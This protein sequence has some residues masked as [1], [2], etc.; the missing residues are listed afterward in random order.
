VSSTGTN[1]GSLV[2]SELDTQHVIHL[3]SVERCMPRAYIRVCLA[4]RVADSQVL[5]GALEKLNTF[6]RRTIDAKPYLSGYVV[7]VQH[8]LANPDG[9]EVRF[10]NRDFI[11]Y[12][13]V[14]VRHLTTKEMPYSYDELSNLG[15]PP[16]TIR[17][18]LVSA[19]PEGTD[20][21]RAP[22][23]RVQANVIDGGIIVSIYLH[24]CISDGT[25]LG[26]LATGKVLNDDFTFERHLPAVTLPQTVPTLTS[27]LAA[28]ANQK[29]IVRKELSWSSPNS[30]PD[31]HLHYKF[32]TSATCVPLPINSPGRGCIVSIPR[33][34]V[35]SLQKRVRAEIADIQQKD[36]VESSEDC[37]ISKTD[38]LQTLLWHHM[39]RARIPSLQD[40]Y[41]VTKSKLLTP[42]SIRDKL[43]RKLP[44]GY[45]GAAIDFAWTE[46]PLKHLSMSDI[47]S[48]AKTAYSIHGSIGRVDESY[49]R[50][51]IALVHSSKGQIDVRDLLASN[52]NRLTGA[53]MYITSWSRLGLYETTLDMGLGKPDWVRKPWSK[54]PGSCI[55]LPLDDN[56]SYW[57]IV[58]QMTENDMSRLLAD[59]E[60]MRYVERVID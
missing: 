28:F 60:F 6:V 36:G 32:V 57:E 4:Y 45:F 10:S 23:F 56:K 1:D 37:T 5:S 18:E 31:R 19:L 55:I 13:P 34:H 47:T 2:Y 27:R 24:H 46:F 20:E 3:S 44:E 30:V 39:T 41:A 25:G 48:L 54:D 17:P 14:N 40:I 8:Q 22:A 59:P 49:V 16:S 38:V 26:L 7:P 35:E 15:L 21:E 12:P 58:V 11:D 50:Q 53:D 42:V 52:M 33:D 51:V 43:K 29:S 9:L